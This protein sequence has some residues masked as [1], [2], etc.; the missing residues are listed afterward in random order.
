LKKLIEN[1]KGDSMKVTKEKNLLL[2]IKRGFLLKNSLNRPKDVIFYFLLDK[3]KQM[4]HFS[5][6]F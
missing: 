4:E 6:F 5:K 1:V 2:A 3:I